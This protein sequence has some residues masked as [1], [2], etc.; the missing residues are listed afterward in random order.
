MK[1]LKYLFCT[2]FFG[3]CLAIDIHYLCENLKCQTKTVH[4][5]Q[6]SNTVGQTDGQTE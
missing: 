4:D 6:T 1:T 2:V 5:I 3:I